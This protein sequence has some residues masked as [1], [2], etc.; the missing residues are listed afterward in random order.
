MVSGK[1]LPSFRHEDAKIWERNVGVLEKKRK[2]K[3]ENTIMGE[4]PL[5][6]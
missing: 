3:K 1:E 6:G 5:L 2:K 4:R